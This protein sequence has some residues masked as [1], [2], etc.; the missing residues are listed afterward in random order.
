MA[1]PYP[2]NGHAA[3]RDAAHDDLAPSGAE[4]LAE[5]L[6]R[7]RLAPGADQGPPPLATP[8]MSTLSDGSER[9]VARVAALSEIAQAALRLGR[10]SECLATL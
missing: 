5:R 3:D 6:R 1:S 10:V 8:W 7:A 4:P 9:P 2:R